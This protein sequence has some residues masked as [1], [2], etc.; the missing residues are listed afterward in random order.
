MN[1]LNNI[2]QLYSLSCNVPPGTSDKLK[3]YF[4]PEFL[5]LKKFQTRF[6]K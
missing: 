2:K 3:V 5:T 1:D 6:Y 4:M